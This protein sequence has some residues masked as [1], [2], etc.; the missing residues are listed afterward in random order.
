MLAIR[1]LPISGASVTLPHKQTVI[2]Y[3]DRLTNTVLA[4]GAVNTLY[5]E[6]G[7]LWGENTDL[8]GFMA[9][10]APLSGELGSALV[11]GAGGAALACLEGLRRLGVKDLAVTARDDSK[12]R[13]LC[14]S[15]GAIAVPW[16]QREEHRADLLINATPL[17]MKGKA[18]GVPPLAPH[19]ARTPLVYDLIYNPVR[20]ALL[21]QAKQQGCRTISGLD[22][23]VHQAAE[24]FWIWTGR[25]LDSQK[26]WDLLQ[27]HL[28]PG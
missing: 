19:P 28:D 17:G 8:A 15:Q 7:E 4:I 18:E 13:A 20:T 10:L 14:S 1:T 21:Q 24:Q 9:P 25:A 26:L 22:M 27:E 12:L 3:L 11:V 2:P 16:S 23:F 6:N 5:W